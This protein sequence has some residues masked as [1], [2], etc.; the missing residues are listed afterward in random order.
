MP[1]LA[2]AM[3]SES[4]CGVPMGPAVG[5]TVPDFR[6]QDQKRIVQTLHA[7]LGPK[8]ALVVFFR[9]ADW[10]HCCKAQRVGLP[11]N[12]SCAVCGIVFGYR[13][14]Q[15]SAA[16]YDRRI[17]EQRESYRDAIRK[18]LED[19]AAVAAD[20]DESQTLCAN[21]AIRPAMPGNVSCLLPF[22]R[23]GSLE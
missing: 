10:S 4:A 6:F 19:F 23:G 13:L 12:A 3:C 2:I 15:N 14:I 17:G 9:S 22:P 21:S 8:G 18:L 11:Q 5:Q 20:S 1:V 16:A 7:S